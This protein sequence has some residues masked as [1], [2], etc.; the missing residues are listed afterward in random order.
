MRHPYPHPAA[1]K[2]EVFRVTH[3]EGTVINIT[4]DCLQGLE[5]LQRIR[6]FGAAQIAGMPQFIARRKIVEDLWVEV[7]VRVGKKPYFHG[8]LIISTI[9]DPIRI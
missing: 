7:P 6:Q 5:F 8:A 4:I 9:A 1:I 2:P 3:A